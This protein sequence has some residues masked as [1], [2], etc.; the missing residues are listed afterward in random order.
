VFAVEDDTDA[1]TIANREEF[2]DDTM[3]ECFVH[4]YRRLFGIWWSYRSTSFPWRRV[5]LRG[6]SDGKAFVVSKTQDLK[7]NDS[8]FVNLEFQGVY[9]PE[10]IFEDYDQN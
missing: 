9:T 6:V 1:D 8:V 3:E 7:K 10:E 4:V 5:L 2:G